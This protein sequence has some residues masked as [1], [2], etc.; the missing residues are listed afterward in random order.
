MFYQTIKRRHV[1]LICSQSL[2]LLLLAQTPTAAGSSQPV[3][4]PIHHHFPTV[5][6]QA[7]GMAMHS[8]YGVWSESPQQ[9]GGG[10]GEVAQDLNSSFDTLGDMPRNVGKIQRIA[11]CIYMPGD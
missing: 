11:D 7:Q 9:G 10:G 3:P 6:P 8:P 5:A 4:T 1:L 2:L